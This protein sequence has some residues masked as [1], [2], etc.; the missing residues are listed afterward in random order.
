MTSD[1]LP[2]MGALADDF[3]F[4]HAL[5]TDTSAHPQGENFMNTGFTMEGFP[6]FGAW[7]TYA[8]GT[9]REDLPAFVALND[10]RGLARS[11]KNNFG[12]GFLPAAF[13]GTDF[14]MKNPP[15]NLSRPG[16]Y[17]AKQD[18]MAVDFLKRL[19]DKHLEKFP[20][21]ADLAGRIASYELAG[22]MQMS[23]PDVMDISGE[24]DYV[25]KEY[26]MEEGSDLK[27]KYAKNCI[28]ARRLLEKGVRVVQLYNG[29]DPSGGNGI[30]NWDSHNDLHKTHGMQA[31]IMDQ[32]TAALISDL[33]RRG[34]LENTLIVWSTEFGRMPFLQ[35]NGT[36]RDHNPDAFT[37]FLAGAGVKKG[38][39]YGES[40]ELGFKV[41][42]NKT[43]IYDFNATILHLMGLDHERLNFYHNG[44]ERRLTNVH[45]HVIKR[46]FKLS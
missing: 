31:E 15:N 20:E 18:Q 13:Q 45:G 26:G 17:S 35:A 5:K 24:P 4:L 33:K 6:S 34:L 7:A 36:G 9:E 40:D 44:L 42:S 29:S 8:L 23:I 25:K 16:A 22:K 1:L 19:N 10:P 37:C 46:Y 30:T 41:G 11:G 3:C 14:N 39:S 27:K 28:L 21:D 12:N 43:T 38:F 2:K 32:P